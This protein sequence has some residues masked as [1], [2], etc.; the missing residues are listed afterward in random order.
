MQD[1]FSLVTHEIL[2]TA[3]TL[4]VKFI[5]PTNSRTICLSNMNSQCAETTLCCLNSISTHIKPLPPPKSRSVSNWFW[6]C[7]FTDIKTYEVKP[8]WH[9]MLFQRTYWTEQTSQCQASIWSCLTY[10]LGICKSPSV[11]LPFKRWAPSHDWFYWDNH[12]EF[13]VSR[14]LLCSE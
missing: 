2:S 8:K 7:W 9:F 3:K 14:F 4:M 6:D 11:Q 10:F 5:W 13:Q 1:R 12:S